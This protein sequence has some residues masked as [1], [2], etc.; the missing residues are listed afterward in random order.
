MLSIV[1][2]RPWL[3]ALVL[4]GAWAQQG[5]AQSQAAQAEPIFA[6][7]VASD[8]LEQARGGSFHVENSMDLSGVTAGNSAHNVATGNN[9]ISAGAFDHAAGLPIVIQN[10]G[11]NVLIQNGV[12]IN[13]QMQ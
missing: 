4:C 3:Y 5:Q 8:Q 1:L 11:A 10:S 12:V 2:R 13:L 6:T 9:A 7:P